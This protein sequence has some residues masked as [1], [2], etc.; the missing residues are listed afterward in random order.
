MTVTITCRTDAA[1]SS[2]ARSSLDH[3][4]NILATVRLHVDD[5]VVTL[6]GSVRQLSERAEAEDVVRY[7]LG[8]QRVVSEITVARLSNKAGFEPPSRVR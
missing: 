6:T 3:R 5:G 2:D 7:V 1:L 8:V 4:P